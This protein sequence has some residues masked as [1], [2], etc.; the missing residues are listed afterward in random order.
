MNNNLFSIWSLKQMAYDKL[1]GQWLSMALITFVFF[2]VSL[3]VAS[4]PFVGFIL[5]FAVLPLIFG[6]TYLVFLGVVRGE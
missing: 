3:L 5:Q 2:L 4:V 6:F 1:R